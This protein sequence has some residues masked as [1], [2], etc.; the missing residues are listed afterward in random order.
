[1]KRK[2]YGLLAAVCLVLVVTPAVRAEDRVDYAVTGGNIRFDKST[3]TVT[4]CGKSVTEASIPNKIENVSVTSIGTGAFE[5]CYSL[6]SVTI[7]D[8]V[9]SIGEYAFFGSYSLTS[10]NIANSVTSIG[11]SAFEDCTDL[12]DVYYDGTRAEY[13][14]KLRPNVDSGNDK[15]LKANIHFT[16]D[17]APDSNPAPGPNPDPTPAPTPTLPNTAD[18]DDTA[19]HGVLFLLLAAL[20]LTVWA[21]G[22]RKKTRGP[23]E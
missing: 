18:S 16:D 19:F 4:G 5:C 10:V 1:M 15:F 12:T 2:I 3:G 9:T 7:P 14:T 23:T 20:T 8:S 6:T 17:P 22:R 11:D 21:L 13:E